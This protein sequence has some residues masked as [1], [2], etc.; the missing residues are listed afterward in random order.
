MTKE[1]KE[2]HTHNRRERKRKPI[3]KKRGTKGH[4]IDQGSM[5]AVSRLF[6]Q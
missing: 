3:T 6:A 2:R 4:G 1:R 5:Q